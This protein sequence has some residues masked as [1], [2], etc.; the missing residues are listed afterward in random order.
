MSIFIDLFQYPFFV[1]AVIAGLMLSF[2]L[3]WLSVFVVMR[4]EV[5]FVHSLANISLFGVALAVYFSL[6][7]STT[8]LFFTVL[9]SFLI[10]QI[11]KKNLFTNDS[12]LA[13]FS[14]ISMALA[15]ILIALFPGYKV[16][17]EQFLF[18][19]ILALS[20]NDIY[21]T[22]VLFVFVVITLILFQKKFL[23]I[24][25][26]DQLSHSL[27]KRKGVWHFLLVMLLAIL[28]ALSI[29]VIGVL[30]VAAFITLP[31]NSAKL[32]AKSIKSTF[33]IS[34]FFGV[35]STCF[36][37]ILSVAFNIPSGPTIVVVLAF[38][39]LFSLMLN[40]VKS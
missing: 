31:S 26:S 14:Q 39:W 35:I 13:L 19:D 33:V 9:A 34:I 11:Q 36:G 17:L 4:K 27:L 23:M 29:K 10:I 38:I 28:V 21:L 40:S 6:T 3:S 16:E 15:V 7:I 5:L 1:R 25:I 30:L 24:S 18:G 32:L 22:I 12:L 2:L 8:A 20:Q 37:L